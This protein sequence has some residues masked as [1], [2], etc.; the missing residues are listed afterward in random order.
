MF[1]RSSHDVRASE[2]LKLATA[3]KKAKDWDGAIAALTEAY[4]EIAQSQLVYSIDTFIRRPQYLQL[5][6]RSKDAWKEFNRL[7]LHG[8]ANQL[9]NDQTK[10][11]DRSILFDKMRLFLLREK[12][13][14]LAAIFSIFATVSWNIGLYRQGR[15]DELAVR[16]SDIDAA[17]MISVLTAYSNPGTIKQLS[18]AI[19]T[20]LR[21]SPPINYR[22]LGIAMDTLI[23]DAVT[24]TQ[25][26]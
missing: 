9:D 1:E 18:D 25:D 10:P 4:Q 26:G 24:G 17:E 22:K 2:L 23:A 20:A 16:S 21:K 7:L 3:R 13:D 19:V 12:Q 5:A 15:K 8:F 14:R 11:M 6:G